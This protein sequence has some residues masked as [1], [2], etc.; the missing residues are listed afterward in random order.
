M[1]EYKDMHWEDNSLFYGKTDTTVKLL[2]D[3]KYEGMYWLTWDFTGERKS[4][5]FY[6]ISTAKDNARALYLRYRNNGAENDCVEG[7]TEV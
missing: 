5:H 4:L 6:N 7:R 3:E 2:K 1:I